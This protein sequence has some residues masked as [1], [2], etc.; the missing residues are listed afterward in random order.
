MQETMPYPPTILCA[1]LPQAAPGQLDIWRRAFEAGLEPWLDARQMEHVRRFG[2]APTLVQSAHLQP[3]AKAFR[4]DVSGSKMSGQNISGPDAAGRRPVEAALSRL[5]ARAQLITAV[6]L[7]TAPGWPQAAEAGALPI[8]TMDNR[9]RPL[10]A[11]WQSGFSHSGAAAFCVLAPATDET[12]TAIAVDAEA[13][14]SPP[15]DASAFA[16]NELTALRSLSQTGIDR[17]ALRR[18]TIKEALLKAAGLGLGMPPALVPTGG[19]GQR[20]GLWR[21]PLGLFGW[22]VAPCPGHWLCV[23]QTGKIPQP[24]RILW[25][26]PC[27]LLRNL[28][29]LRQ[30]V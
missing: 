22:R 15:P 23:A 17:D 27:E 20:A 9:T 29:R 25:Q 1:P 11:G 5:M 4:P 16:A 26:T 18:W 21:G 30:H 10:L 12:R 6:G 24:P 7:P 14:T 28:A 2:R 8:I 13:I 3:D 19:S